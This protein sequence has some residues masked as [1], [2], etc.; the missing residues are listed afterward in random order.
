MQIE[1]YLVVKLRIIN[2]IGNNFMIN[3][4][5]NMIN[6]FTTAYQYHLK[7]VVPTTCNGNISWTE[8]DTASGRKWKK[9]EVGRRWAP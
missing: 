8:L 5:I 3:I 4:N 6:N 7:A 9:T 1:H 2:S